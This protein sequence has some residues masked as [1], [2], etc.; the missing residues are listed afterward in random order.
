MTPTPSTPPAARRGA[1]LLRPLAAAWG[2]VRRRPGR[3]LAVLLLLG[4]IAFGL[5]AA[6]VQLWA[7][8]HLRAAR[9][10]V[11][12]YQSQD[13]EEHIRA[14]LEVW[15]N[16]PEVLLLA[17][18]ATRR[19][20]LFDEAE[21]FL[22]RYQEVRGRDDELT[23]ERALL[24]AE[25]GDVDDVA[26]F[27]QA[28]VA[29]NDPETP[30]I[31]EALARGYLRAFRTADAE[32]AVETWLGRDAD[33]P[34][35]H[36]LR[37]RVAESR[38]AQTA[39]AGAYRRALELDP[40]L[41]AARDRLAAVLVE[42]YQAPEAL[43]HLEY[44]RRHRPDDPALAVRLAQCYDLLGEQEKAARL[45]DEVLARSPDDT[46]ALA[47]RGKL[48]LRAGQFADAEAWLRRAAARSPGDVTILR[49]LRDCLDQSGQTEAARELEPRL[50]QA[51]GDLERIQLLVEQ[52]IQHHPENAELQYEAGTILLRIGSHAQ[53]VRWLENA[54]RLNPRHVKAHEAL[55]DFY[56][57]FGAGARAAKHRRQ[58]REAAEAAKS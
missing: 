22:D 29:A 53:G 4:L 32:R 12:R 52:E 24:T 8:Y 19:A 46:T 37:G 38:S 10:A 25:R 20:G 17:A 48:A 3:A 49:P 34:M 55:A 15:P 47:E 54:V 42:M 13:A 45:L 39:A 11:A 58:A 50:K 36:F 41:D 16:D 1:A 21:G 35:A 7:A 18:R 5:S 23:L 33:D 2:R 31:L 57:Q 44:L 43:P 30:L 51:Q 26:K 40:D 56:Q 14:C 9:A 6:G 28:K 27:C